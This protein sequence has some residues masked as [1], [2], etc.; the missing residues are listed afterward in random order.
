MVSGPNEGLEPSRTRIVAAAAL[1]FVF[2][3][4]FLVV[5]VVVAVNGITDHGNIGTAARN[6]AGGRFSPARGVWSLVILLTVGG[7]W[8]IW[9]A[10]SA[11]WRRSYFGI[12]IPLGVLL[13]F[14]TIGEVIDLFG[15]ASSTSDLVGAGILVLAAIPVVLLWRPV[16]DSLR[17][18]LT[19]R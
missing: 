19:A 8:L 3:G 11:I 12:V 9:S 5:A 14:G 4:A 17:R 2:G 13:V 18:W 10:V 1:A 15:T 7:L 6:T 16:L